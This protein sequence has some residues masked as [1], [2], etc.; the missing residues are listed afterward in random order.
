MVIILS[1]Q[2]KEIMKIINDNSVKF[3]F[4]RGAG[5]TGKTYAI[6]Q[7][8]QALGLNSSQYVFMGPTGKSV[9]VAE[10]KGLVGSTLHRFFKIQ[11]NDSTEKLKRHINHKFRG[12]D[13]YYIEMRKELLGVKLVFIDEISM[14]NDQLLSHILETLLECMSDDCKIFLSGDFNQL[15][16]VVNDKELVTPIQIIENIIK[17]EETGLVD[18]NTRFR[19]D[20]EEFNKFLHD[21]RAGKLKK[22]NEI[23]KSLRQFFNVYNQATYPKELEH[24]L[25]FLA[26]GN[27]KVKIINDA[28]LDELEGDLMT[29]TR[30]IKI[31]EFPE[32]S[33][34]IR[35]A[36]L[37]DFQMDDSVSFK[38]GSKVLFRVNNKDD[39]FKNGDEGI[40]EAIKE[41]SVVVRKLRTNT[42]IEVTKHL[43]KST[44]LERQDGFIIEVEQW[45]FS[46]GNAR[47]IHK[48]QGD[49]FEF[50]HLDFDFLSYSNTETKWAL[51]YVC[52]SRIIDPSKVWISDISIKNLECQYNMFKNINYK[53]LGLFSTNEDIPEY[54]ERMND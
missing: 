1:K 13:G 9:A 24:S 14:V 5:G 31:D 41:R 38:V 49:G 36:I 40:I 37:A 12:I 50:L 53:K 23:S 16:P 46:L 21:L 35:D 34:D 33:K 3:G 18:F 27:P 2:V 19:S 17:L 25:T 8:I 32:G 22:V 26:H 11:T 42:L 30:T 45:P 20:N 39:Q 28:L 54:E 44:D 6:A 47:T 48:S 7:T 29:H 51:L 10:E 4:L 52:L 43:Y 15:A